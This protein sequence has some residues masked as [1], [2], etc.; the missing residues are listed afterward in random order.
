MMAP[1]MH[2]FTSIGLACGGG[3]ALVG[4]AGCDEAVT[5]TSES[6]C[7]PCGSIATG[8]L[9]IAGDARLDG[10][11]QAV[12]D[13]RN[14]TASIRAEV[15]TDVRALGELYGIAGAEVDADYVARLRAA[16]EADVRTSTDGGLR[17]V[18]DPARCQADVA[19]AVRAQASCEAQAG[20]DVYVQPGMIAVECE[21]TCRG[22]CSGTC[23]GELACAVK[24]PTVACE[25]ECE[26]SCQLEGSAVCSGA[27]RGE[28]NGSCSA[29][30]ENGE[31]AGRCR[32]Q[33]RGVCELEGRA[34]CQGT[35]QGTCY[36]DPGSA[37]CNAQAQ[38]AGSC[39]AACSGACE[40]A[41]EPP[42]ASASCEASVD[43]Q[44]QARAQAQANLQCSP[45]RLDID[46]AFAAGLDAEARAAFIARMRELRIRAVAILQGAARLQALVTGEVDG[47]VVFSPAPLVAL[48]GQIESIIEAGLEG[49][50]EIA[51]GRIACVIPAFSA[52]VDALIGAGEDVQI[53]LA[54]SAE[55]SAVFQG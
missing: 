42:R 7:G 2:R 53:T 47:R 11:F 25:G 13:L 3:L 14:A 6:L 17:V 32:G 45:P 54:A 51:P 27:C 52:A 10:F 49:R 18:L 1:V 44:A 48:R 31:C 9:S 24:T 41:F 19:V 50:F 37:Q 4:L 40:G 21:G 33:C 39:D 20:C 16:I 15:E 22:E 23:S 38:C 30:N 34:A 12:A 43:C 35:C 46:F 28:C 26:G 36:V 8:N 5:Q 55:F 29:T